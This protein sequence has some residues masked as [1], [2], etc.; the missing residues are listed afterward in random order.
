[1]L[2]LDSKVFICPRGTPGL[3]PLQFEM[4]EVYKAEGRINEVAFVTSE[5]A[6]ELLATFNQAFLILTRQITAVDL[7]RQKA[8]REANKRRSVVIL[9]L[10]PSI[11]KE[12][13]LVK[14]SNPAGSADLREAVLDADA[15]YLGLLDKADQIAAV[16]ELLKGKLKAIEMAYTSV[17]KILGESA[18]NYNTHNTSAPNEITGEAGTTS[19]IHGAF[20]KTRY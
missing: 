13:H 2:T 6:P 15:E 17:K 4:G 10:A 19:N 11:L 12:K 14:D 1:M 5:K 8:V 7:E 18:F 9:D 16:Q 3:A 20:G